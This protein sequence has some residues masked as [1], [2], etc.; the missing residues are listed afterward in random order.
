MNVEQQLRAGLGDRYQ[1]ERQIG[2]GGMA[3]VFLARDLKHDRPV[4]IK[5][6]RPELAATMGA[7]RFFHEIELSARLQHPTSCRSTTRELL[8]G[9]SIS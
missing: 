9:S 7:D 5:V 2:E 6:F 1:I 8:A 3:T 4:A